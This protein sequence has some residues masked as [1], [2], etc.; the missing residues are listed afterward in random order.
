MYR[1]TSYNVCYTKLL[2]T[3]GK[4]NVLDYV[5][6]LNNISGVVP[7]NFIY[8]NRMISLIRIGTSKKKVILRDIFEKG[9]NAISDEELLA[10]KRKWFGVDEIE[11]KDKEKLFS[12]EEKQS[13]NFV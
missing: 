11:K 10:L 6:F 12:E 8:D 13:Y 5:I 9:M 2:R 7:T 1:I 3:I 4:K